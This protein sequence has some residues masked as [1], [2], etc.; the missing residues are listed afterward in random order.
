MRLA[1]ASQARAGIGARAGADRSGTATTLFSLRATHCVQTKSGQPPTS[2][3]MLRCS[4][5]GGDDTDQLV[6]TD[7]LAAARCVQTVRA[8]NV[9]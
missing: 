9:D 8:A 6:H 2:R 5:A 3:R 7:Q 1:E 4:S